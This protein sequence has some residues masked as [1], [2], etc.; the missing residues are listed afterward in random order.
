MA[1]TRPGHRAKVIGVDLIEA[2][3][4][5]R[6]IARVTKYGLL[7]VVLAF[8]T[9]VLFELLSGVRVALLQYG[10]L[11]ASLSLFTLLLLLVSELAGYTAGYI[12]SAAMVTAQAS[13]Y[14]LSVTRHLRQAGIFAAMLSTVF[15]FLYVLLSLVSY[16][17]VVGSMAIFVVLSILMGVTQKVQRADDARAMPLAHAVDAGPGPRQM[18]LKPDQSYF[19]TAPGPGSPVITASNTGPN[20]IPTA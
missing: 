13:L 19:P 4:V 10:L 12:L 17:L 7:I 14:T 15:G 18:T 9:Y 11:G 16:A 3:P 6:T 8:S 2:T 1:S 5:Y 20:M